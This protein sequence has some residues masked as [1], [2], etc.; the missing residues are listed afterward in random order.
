MIAS[1]HRELFGRTATLVSSISTCAD[2]PL[3][4]IASGKPNPAFGESAE[5]FQRDWGAQSRTLAGRSTRGRLILAEGACHA[6]DEDVPDLV[7]ESIASV[8]KQ[9]RAK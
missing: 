1:E 5:E 7:V 9:A 6:L 8:V 3:I 2:T 4:V